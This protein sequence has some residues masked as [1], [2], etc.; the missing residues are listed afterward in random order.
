MSAS[1][2]VGAMIDDR[3]RPVHDRWCLCDECPVVERREGSAGGK[4]NPHP[5]D[6]AGMLTRAMPHA[7]RLAKESS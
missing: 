3:V 4:K 7:P 2:D 6:G 5:G 1:K